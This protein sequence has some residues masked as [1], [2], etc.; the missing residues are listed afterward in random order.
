MA[1]LQ[2]IE[3]FENKMVSGLLGTHRRGGFT[4]QSKDGC[5]RENQ[6]ENAADSAQVL[7]FYRP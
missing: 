7:P 1:N 5:G 6:S 3:L 4:S 2:G